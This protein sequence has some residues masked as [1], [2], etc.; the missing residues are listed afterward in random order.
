[1]VGIKIPLFRCCSIYI[2]FKFVLRLFW[3]Y[4]T[5][6]HCHFDVVVQR[7]KFVLLSDHK[8]SVMRCFDATL[9]QRQNNVRE[10]EKGIWKGFVWY[11]LEQLVPNF[12]DCEVGEIHWSFNQRLG[13]KC[14]PNLLAKGQNKIFGRD[15]SHNTKSRTR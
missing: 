9:M 3:D 6:F 10:E 1:M 14:Q 15:L 8:R 5:L 11:I 2:S 4:L 7:R 13:R 12:N